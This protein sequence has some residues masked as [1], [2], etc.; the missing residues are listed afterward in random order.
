[1]QDTPDIIGLM[2]NDAGGNSEVERLVVLDTHKAPLNPAPE[3]R[4]GGRWYLREAQAES[5]AYNRSR[6]SSRNEEVLLVLGLLRGIRIEE[7]RIPALQLRRVVDSEADAVVVVLEV[8][9]DCQ[10]SLSDQGLND[11]PLNEDFLVDV[12]EA[13]HG[14]QVNIRRGRRR[15]EVAEA[16]LDVLSHVRRVERDRAI[17]CLP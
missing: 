10:E 4:K 12:E 6:D 16:V 14:L 17:A 15:V 3:P 2:A 5:L 9:I 8:L 11:R 7:R 13:A 1:M